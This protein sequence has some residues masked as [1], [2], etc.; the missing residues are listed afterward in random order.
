[1][2]TRSE[3]FGG[4]KRRQRLNFARWSQ[5]QQTGSI[6]GQFSPMLRKDS[7]NAQDACKMIHCN[8]YSLDKMV[9]AGFIKDKRRRKAHAK[10][11]FAKLD[12][13][14][15][16]RVAAV[17][18]KRMKMRE[19][20]SLLGVSHKDEVEHIVRTGRVPA[21]KTTAVVGIISRLD[22]IEKQLQNIGQ[23][24]DTLEKIWS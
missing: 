6:A 8:N 20:K 17:Y 13:A 14:D 21:P 16:Q 19:L 4:A 3:R 7:M 18:R 24:L 23:Q 1:M 11:H 12:Q 9:E 5:A 2:V 10:K 22:A 15:V